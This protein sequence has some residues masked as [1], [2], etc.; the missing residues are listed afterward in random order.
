MPPPDPRVALRLDA[1][2]AVPAAAPVLPR[3]RFEAGSRLQYLARAERSMGPATEYLIRSVTVY[4]VR[5]N[6]DG[7]WRLILLE[8]ETEQVLDPEGGLAAGP[9]AVY[10]AW[11]DMPADGRY[12]KNFALRLRDIAALFLPLPR[13]AAEAARWRVADAAGFDSRSFTAAGF[14]RETGR[15]LIRS[16][17]DGLINQ[18]YEISAEGAALFDTAAGRLVE[19]ETR[20]AASRPMQSEMK[21]AAALTPTPPL[22][23]AEFDRFT[24]EAEAFIGAW[25][26]WDTLTDL[27]RE[28]PDSADSLYA[29]AD[30]VLATAGRALTVPD[31]VAAAEG[32]LDAFR[33][34]VEQLAERPAPR[35]GPAP[36]SLL[37][38]PAPVWKYKALDGREWS[39]ARLRGKVVVLDFWYRG[40]TWCIRA[41]PALKSLAAEFAGRPVQ[42]IG[43][44]VDKDPADA[45]FVAEKLGLNYP[46]LLAPTAPRLY[47]VGSYPTL[48]LVDRKG[49][50]AEVKVGYSADLRETLSRR[51]T[52]LL[53]AK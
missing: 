4:P 3:Y 22:P 31:L 19:S 17:G 27:A 39:L 41:M 7:T 5:R 18:V 35:A 13:D 37:G 29:L 10:L 51:I 6:P 52:E 26:R 32:E 2:E 40:C 45:R 9:A 46:T 23:R 30:S 21:T 34:Y 16:V 36:D 33:Y 24:A 48:V 28:R 43:L 12:E 11:C 1:L 53:E 8:R 49:R 44:N 15:L 38:K 25:H 14:E 20:T 50:V 42:I 47:N